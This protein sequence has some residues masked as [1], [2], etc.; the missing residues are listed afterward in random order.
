MSR[1]RWI[2]LGAV[3][4]VAGAAVVVILK[5]GNGHVADSGG[6]VRTPSMDTAKPGNPTADKEHEL[7]ALAVELQK[8]PKHVPILFRMAQ[9]SR[10]LGRPADAVTQLKQVVEVEPK[11]TD[12]HL[13][14]G[15]ALYEINDLQ[16][17]ID[18]TKRVLELDP[19]QVDALYNL[20]AIYANLNRTD[21]AREY[22]SRAVAAAPDSDSGKR[23][24][25]G[26]RKL[27]AM[28]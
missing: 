15:R 2:Q 4:L 21:L 25:D 8:K 19:K 14:L 11:N 6:S 3:L 23:A 1:I 26:L 16:G 17:S 13:E 5:V 22:W 24:E 28:K 9:L 7:K 10:E 27:G 20:G 18:Q 12:A